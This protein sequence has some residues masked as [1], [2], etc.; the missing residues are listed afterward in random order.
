VFFLALLK[1]TGN[2]LLLTPQSTNYIQF[3][4]QRGAEVKNQSTITS[5][6]RDDRYIYKKKTH[7][8]KINISSLRSES[9]KYYIIEKFV[10]HIK[11]NKFGSN[12][13]WFSKILS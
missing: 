7:H 3:P 11:S 5:P 9:K 10:K 6:K 13:D 4:F 2:F 1:I 12:L 8:C